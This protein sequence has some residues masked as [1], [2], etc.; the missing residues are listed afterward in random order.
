MAS[1]KQAWLAA[2]GSGER[3]LPDAWVK[4]RPDLLTAWPLEGGRYQPGIQNG[5][6]LIYYA[7]KEK[8][9]IAVARAAGS[10]AS[11]DTA[12]SIQMYLAIPLIKWAPSWEVLGKPSGSITGTRAITLTD[13][14]YETGLRSFLNLVR[15]RFAD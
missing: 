1:N 12:L 14:E 8:K 7:A 11:T 4:E 10:A 15:E 13:D 9:L 6:H 5:D 2:V 3:P